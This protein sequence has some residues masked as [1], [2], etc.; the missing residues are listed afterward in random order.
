MRKLLIAP[1]AAALL[2]SC[3]TRDYEECA[4]DRVIGEWGVVNKTHAFGEFDSL[5]YIVNP[6]GNVRDTVYYNGNYTD[7]YY[8]SDPVRIMLRYTV[9]DSIEFNFDRLYVTETNPRHMVMMVQADG[10]SLHREC[11]LYLNKDADNDNLYKGTSDTL[12]TAMLR[13]G[14]PLSI[15]ATN[16][17]STSEPQGSQNYEFRLY[18]EGFEKALK[19]AEG[20]NPR[21][22]RKDSLKKDSTANLTKKN[23]KH[24]KF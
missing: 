5:Y 16:G 6:I 12:F 7:S 3:S 10:D 22:E 15:Q 4:A 18:P 11:V 19:M 14:K 20:L 21:P 24:H 9:G 13:E 8:H 17:P 1:V 2:A 23:S